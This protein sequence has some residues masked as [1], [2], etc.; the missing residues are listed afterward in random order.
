MIVVTSVE[1]HGYNTSLEG[2]IDSDLANLTGLARLKT[3]NLTNT[4]VSDK[5]LAYLKGLPALES[6]YLDATRV[7]DAGLPGL[8]KLR[9]LRELH[10]SRNKITDVGADQLTQLHKLELLNLSNTNVS[11]ESVKRLRAA[12]PKCQ[13]MW[14]DANQKDSHQMPAEIELHLTQPS[15]ENR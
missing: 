9:G 14:R 11:E 13:I 4:V 15:V 8:T 10:L 7:T 1:S 3:L 2:I 5:G 6:L 12:L